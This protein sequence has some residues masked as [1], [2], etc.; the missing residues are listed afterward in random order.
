V[1]YDGRIVTSAPTWIGLPPVGEGDG[2]PH[3]SGSLHVIVRGRVSNTRRLH[4]SIDDPPPVTLEQ[5]DHPSADQHR[6]GEAAW[7]RSSCRA[8]ASGVQAC[9]PQTL[10]GSPPQ[11][12]GRAD[13]CNDATERAATTEGQAHGAHGSQLS[14]TSQGRTLTSA[15]DRRLSG[16][17]RRNPVRDVS[18][19]GQ[20]GPDT[21]L[22]RGRSRIGRRPGIRVVRNS[23]FSVGS[24]SERRGE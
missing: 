13:R 24:R 23:L 3:G 20:A 16:F 5:L 9:L 8:A 4:L 19:L 11:R 7:S 2:L 15:V 1:S 12:R 14:S 18:A 17:P 10:V 22:P 21:F 6:A